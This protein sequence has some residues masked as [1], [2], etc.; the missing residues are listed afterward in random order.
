MP[1]DQ[2]LKEIFVSF[3]AKSFIIFTST[4]LAVSM[5]CPVKRA[6]CCCD[7][8]NE[9]GTTEQWLK[10]ELKGTKITQRAESNCDVG[11]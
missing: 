11:Y 2:L 3:V 7:K 10:K 8:V 5:C 6:S 1:S 9:S 4:L